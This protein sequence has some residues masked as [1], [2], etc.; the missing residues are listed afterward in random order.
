MTVLT[1]SQR[2]HLRGLAHSSRPA[3][4]IGKGGLTESVVRALDDALE[5]RE[6]IK[7]KIAAD[8]GER[9]EMVPLIEARLGCECVGE[10][11]HM[12]IFFRQ[13]PD[14]EKRAVS[15]PG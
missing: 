3:V 6:L 12:A 14:P 4:Q 2:K 15:I 10:V 13:H 9:L 5:S 7:V 8:R 11:G 1:G